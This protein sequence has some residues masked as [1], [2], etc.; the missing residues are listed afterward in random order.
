MRVQGAPFMLGFVNLLEIY[1][2]SEDWIPGLLR[3]GWAL[4]NMANYKGMVTDPAITIALQLFPF[5][6]SWAWYPGRPL[7]SGTPASLRILH[8]SLLCYHM[9][10]TLALR[11]LRVLLI[12]RERSSKS[13]LLVRLH[14]RAILK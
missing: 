12:S 2:L 14:P 6:V 8:F 9:A 5:S 11:C 7:E 10:W 1:G 13:L 4:R 3:K